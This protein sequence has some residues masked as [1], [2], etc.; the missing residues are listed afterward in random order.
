MLLEKYRG[1]Y[2]ERENI[3]IKELDQL[4]NDE[5]LK[6]II[7]LNNMEMCDLINKEPLDKEKIRKLFISNI[8]FYRLARKRELSIPGTSIL[9]TIANVVDYKID[10]LYAELTVGSYKSIFRR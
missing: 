8:N 3:N 1:E 2:F 5:D 7:G 6:N 9:M 10:K 4:I